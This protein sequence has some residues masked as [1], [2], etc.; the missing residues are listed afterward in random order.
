MS[1]VSLVISLVQAIPSFIKFV[2]FLSDLMRDD[3]KEVKK[4]YKQEAQG[5]FKRWREHRDTA[6]SAVELRDVFA[7]LTNR[8]GI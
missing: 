3:P 2:Q 8:K 1:W 4:E 7:K 6:K 5:I